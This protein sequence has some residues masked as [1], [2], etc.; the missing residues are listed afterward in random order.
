VRLSCEI[1]LR[2]EREKRRSERKEGRDT[3]HEKKELIAFV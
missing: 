2:K 1:G 3:R